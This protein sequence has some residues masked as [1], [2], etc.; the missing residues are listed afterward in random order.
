MSDRLIKAGMIGA[1]AVA[2][3]KHGKT[4][5]GFARAVDLATAVFDELDAILNEEAKQVNILI[6]Q[7][8]Q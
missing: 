5:D 8:T 3:R 4:W 1:F 7:V 6:R 2:V